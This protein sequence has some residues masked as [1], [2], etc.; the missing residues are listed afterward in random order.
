VPAEDVP[1]GRLPAKGIVEADVVNARNPE[2]DFD[3]SFFQSV[4]KNLGCFRHL[5]V[6][7]RIV[8]GFFDRMDRM[9]GIEISSWLT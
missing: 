8:K 3:P 4:D 6:S 5:G 1:D 2:N 7:S 9:D